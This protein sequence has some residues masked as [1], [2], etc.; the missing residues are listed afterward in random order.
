[1]SFVAACLPAKA[2]AQTVYKRTLAAT[3]WINTT[4][5]VPSGGQLSCSVTADISDSNAGTPPIITNHI[6]SASV[7][8]TISSASS[9]Y[10]TVDIP[11]QWSLYSPGSDQIAINY[12]VSIISGSSSSSGATVQRSSS[13]S[14]G[15]IG[16]PTNG[17]TA[18]VGPISVRL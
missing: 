6:E 9:A 16:L 5:A 17:G 4:T 7:I 18:N 15:A 13:A 12:S 1:L 11:F 10:C 14:I 3:F 8:A 2:D